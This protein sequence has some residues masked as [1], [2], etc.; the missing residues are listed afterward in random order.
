MACLSVIPP[1]AAPLYT[2]CLCALLR[3]V[4]IVAVHGLSRSGSESG[5]SVCDLGPFLGTGVQTIVHAIFLRGMC[6]SG[7]ECVL[8]LVRPAR[9][10]RHGFCTCPRLQLSTIFCLPKLDPQRLAAMFPRCCLIFLVSF[11]NGSSAARSTRHL[12]QLCSAE[13]LR[14]KQA[15]I[16]ARVSGAL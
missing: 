4:A 1:L 3:S 10:Y 9:C 6:V 15:V 12:S 16:T 11:C 2:T 7:E 5:P 8:R 14:G 13:F